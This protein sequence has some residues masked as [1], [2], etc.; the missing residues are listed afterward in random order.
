MPFEEQKP[1]MSLPLRAL[2]QTYKF[3]DSEDWFRETFR[4]NKTGCTLAT[5]FGNNTIS[6]R[7]DGFVII[8]L[9]SLIFK[10]LLTEIP[11]DP[12]PELM[13]FTS[14]GCLSC[15]LL[16]LLNKCLYGHFRYISTKFLL[17]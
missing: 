6:I 1:P 10:F 4:G 15:F 9:S 14:F 7:K 5:T 8:W 16:A 2:Y 12:F 13:S 3:L 11:T 17:W